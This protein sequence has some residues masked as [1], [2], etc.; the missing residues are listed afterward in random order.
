MI[1]TGDLTAEL[2]D[3][4]KAIGLFTSSG[5]LDVSWFGEPLKRLES[6]LSSP[7]Q[8]AALL[9]LL[10]GFFPPATNIPDLAAGE[11]WH[12]LLGDQPLGNLYFTEIPGEGGTVFGMAGEIHGSGA[13][14]R[15]SLRVSMPIFE[16]ASAI[17]VEFGSQKFPL[18]ATLTVQL[19]DLLSSTQLTL[20][21]VRVA[22]V[23][24]TSP[25]S[26]SVKITL[27]GLS[28]DGAPAQNVP[29]D[30]ANLK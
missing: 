5:D 3:L 8:R 23:V 20:D 16:A 30:A 19:K 25:A 11:K 13:T 29:L 1:S 10:N 18:S 28:I 7:D 15:A 17:S 14:P 6:M 24:S 27:E 12:P 9:D 2:A 4:G 26:E 21:A 22:A